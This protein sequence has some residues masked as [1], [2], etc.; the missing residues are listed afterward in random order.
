MEKYIVE[1]K[2][3][4]FA[5]LNNSPIAYFCTEFGVEESLPIFAGGLGILA[6]DL[7]LEAG[8]QGL[9]FVGVG[10]FYHYSFAIHVP[11]QDVVLNG[12]EK[13]DPAKA[14]FSILKDAGE[15]FLIGVEVGERI[16]YARTWTKVYGSA[17]LFLLDTDIEINN[18][19]D[20]DITGYLYHH[21]MEAKL[22]Q[23]LVLGIGGVKLLRRLG[24]VPSIYHLNEGHTSFAALAIAVEYTHD[25]PETHSL[26]SAIDEVKKNI[27]ASKHTVLPA[28]GVFF[29]KEQFSGVL[30]KYLDRHNVDYNEFFVMGKSDTDGGW[31]S[32]TRFLIQ[33]IIRGNAVSILH[34]AF[35]KKVHPHSPLFG[36]TNGVNV[37][38]WRSKDWPNS[39]AKEATDEILLAFKTKKRKELIDL[40]RQK[41]GAELDP[42]AMTIVWARR[43][44]PYKRPDLIFSD[45]ER[46]VNIFESKE[47]PMQII[48]A[49]NASY[50]NEE[51]KVL[52]D[53]ILGLIFDPRLKG[54]AVYLPGY[55]IDMAH[56]LIE[57][58]D[59]W[60]NTPI[61]GKEACATSGM[62][63][64][65]NGTLQLSTSDGWIE[66]V[67]WADK[68]WV[69]PAEDTANN[70]YEI[71]EK[72]VVP[73]FYRKSEG[74]AMEWASKMRNMADRAESYY[75]TDRMLNEYL[76]KLYFPK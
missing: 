65:L 35:E 49:G 16:I 27:V 24:I 64:A 37:D 21:N 67:E 57:G 56:V 45:L 55:S 32:S 62:K 25:H 10:L 42:N 8:K 54:R 3:G 69:L 48:L 7:L 22:L 66:E 41:T 20:R 19:E 40:V 28:S 6:G 33:S 14:G 39:P 31:F 1:S 71:L 29:S 18:K 4:K 23:E 44:A 58:A 51:G 13:L 73:A 74:V 15:D 26:A 12:E 46:L 17:H 34:A 70:L 59:V 9:P 38:R 76:E 63:A 75:T 11:G 60:L 36:I 43:F 52:L 68:G 30:D 2:N 5:Y 53:K 50:D 72:E 47:G 61:R